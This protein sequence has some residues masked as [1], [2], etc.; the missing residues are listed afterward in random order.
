M[1]NGLT[2]NLSKEVIINGL[3]PAFEGTSFYDKDFT[4]T[5]EPIS[6]KEYDA[7]KRRHTNRKK[8]TNEAAFEKELFLRQVK[9]W[10]NFRDEKNKEILYSDKIKEAIADQILFFTRAVNIACLTARTEANEEEV[11]N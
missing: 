3:N 8:E 10:S 9:D 4:I 2:I 11:K 5:V 7:I 6:H 1:F